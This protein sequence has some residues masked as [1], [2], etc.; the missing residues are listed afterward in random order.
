MNCKDNCKYECCS[1]PRGSRGCPG[2]RGKRGKIGP[3]G[4]T[5]ATGIK[6]D[7]GMT[8][9]KGPDGNTGPDGPPGGTTGPVG[10]TGPSSPPG[11]GLFVFTSANSSVAA[12]TYFIG[13]GSAVS[14]GNKVPGDFPLA[15]GSDISKF[16]SVSVL[17][18]V[19]GKV[20]NYSAILKSGAAGAEYHI[21]LAALNTA[22]NS[23]RLL[24]N[25]FISVTTDSE[26][27]GH[28]TISENL[29][30]CETLSPWVQNI[31]DGG[32]DGIS[33]TVVFE[34]D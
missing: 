9:D 24:S 30:Q 26:P 25:S 4:M 19:N 16:S 29:L 6:G 7:T 11:S 15:S 10:P 18:P 33:V 2:E 21:Y 32:N 8:G 3:T 22:Q 13:Q 1:G 14:V 20:V 27:C 12:G 34:A 5:G 28:L 17:S 23:I 31:T